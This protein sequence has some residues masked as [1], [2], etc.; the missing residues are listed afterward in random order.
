MGGNM[1]ARLLEKGHT[2]SGYNRTRSKGEG[3]GIVGMKTRRS[4]C[5]HSQ[6]S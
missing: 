5:F 4:R 2:V 6:T 1:V 3:L